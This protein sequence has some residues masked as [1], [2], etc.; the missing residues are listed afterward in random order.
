VN[1][2][3]RCGEALA[4]V[5]SIAQCLIDRGLGTERTP[6]TVVAESGAAFA[7]PIEAVAPAS[8][9]VVPTRGPGSIN[10]HLVLTHRGAIVERL[11]AVDTASDA[12]VLLLR[13]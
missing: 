1:G 4:A 5:R 7:K 8:T 10:S 13:R 2:S 9:P 6:G 11:F 12:E 3:P